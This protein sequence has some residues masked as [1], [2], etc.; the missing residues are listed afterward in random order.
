MRPPKKTRGVVFK[1]LLAMCSSASAAEAPEDGSEACD[2]IYRLSMANYDTR[3]WTSLREVRS[4]EDECRAARWHNYR[5]A[6]AQLESFV[7]NHALALSYV[8]GSDS[9]APRAEDAT[10][11]GAF[12]ALPALDYIVGE[13]KGH[14]VVMVNERHHVSADR[15]LT[16][17]LLDP[18]AK[19]GFRYLALEA[20]S[21]EDPINDRRYPVGASGYYTNDVV[22]GELIRSAIQLGYEI[23]AYE[24]MPSQR[25]TVEAQDPE[26]A[27]KRQNNRDSWQARNIVSRVLET[28]PDAK[29]LVH[30][31][32]AHLQ[33]HKRK[34]WLPMAY[35]LRQLT[36]IDPLTVDQTALSERSARHFEH[37]LR[38]E[39]ARRGLLDEGP[40]VL[41][42]EDG[43]HLR[44]GRYA[45]FVDVNVLSAATKYR[46]GRPLWMAMWGRRRSVA[47]DVPEC[48]TKVCIVEARHPDRS[49]EVPYDRMEADHVAS[50]A[51]YLPV[52]VPMKVESFDLDGR[53]L[54]Q[55]AIRPGLDAPDD[56]GPDRD[57]RKKWP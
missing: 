12:S 52:D 1:C 47:V 45:K 29:V 34:S 31:G 2:R 55:R 22:F 26:A 19:Q 36:G 43:G 46:R 38:I 37:P 15:L 9:K 11:F 23:V 27:R 42:D 30:C 32:Y 56:L 40:V 3:I 54:A 18:L 51:L 16:M 17:A 20:L 28:E 49:D 35:V 10:D 39:A 5:Y 53:R 6:R 8:D 7:G 50:A 24:E 48:K 25:I 33:E 57:E 44:V 4:L 13:A 21:Y 14:Q 41:L